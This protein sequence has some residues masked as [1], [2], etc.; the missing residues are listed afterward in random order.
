[1]VTTI[2]IPT[3][4]GI[5]ITI[6]ATNVIAT[7]YWWDGE[8]RIRAV[9]PIQVLGWTPPISGAGDT[10]Q[11]GA[12]KNPRGNN[13]HDQGLDGRSPYDSGNLQATPPITLNVNDVLLIAT[14]GN[15]NGQ[16]HTVVRPNFPLPGRSRLEYVVSLHVIGYVPAADAFR[17]NP[18]GSQTARQIAAKGDVIWS[19]LPSLLNSAHA[20]A[21]AIAQMEA[22]F[23][24]YMGDSLG[25]WTS[26]QIAPNQQHPG[27]GSY[28]ASAVSEALALVCSDLPLAQKQRL[29]EML[30]QQGIDLWGAFRD[31]RVNYSNGGHLQARKALVI[32]AGHMLG[33]E[34]MA[35]P[36]A[37]LGANR[38]REQDAY[39]QNGTEAW[40]GWLHRWSYN[41]GNASASAYEATLPSTWSV[42]GRDDEKFWE[43]YH[44][45]AT[46]GATVGQAIVMGLLGRIYEWGIQAYASVWMHM[47]VKPSAAMLTE[48][49]RTPEHFEYWHAVTLSGG[50]TLGPEYGTVNSF[51]GGTGGMF[52]SDS[53]PLATARAQS[54]HLT[55]DYVL[56]VKSD[57]LLAVTFDRPVYG[58]PIKVECFNADPATVASRIWFGPQLSIPDTDAGIWAAGTA[59]AN[60][61]NIYGYHRNSIT[62]PAISAASASETVWTLVVIY[63][64]GA[65][66]VKADPLTLNLIVPVADVVP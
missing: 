56:N 25:G 13:D 11:N 10:R 22:I 54:P 18:Q 27:Y 65:G 29:T 39:Y 5:T 36:D 17:P 2:Q 7:D 15:G 8:P 14:S 66:Y 23:D 53:W 1:M 38:F 35:N 33:I 55:R 31:G 34:A 28:I 61:P 20:D 30:I 40:Q 63:D 6:A 46:L 57:Y 26:D 64:T 9:G 3:R 59:N 52:V 47:T 50:G 41:R 21:P 32:F 24:G 37:T 43:H 62:I 4:R 51:R 16:D 60:A 48:T 49:S 44:G 45:N 42:V 12:W 19:R 58:S